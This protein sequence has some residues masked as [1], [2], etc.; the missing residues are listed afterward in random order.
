MKKPKNLASHIPMV[1]PDIED[2]RHEFFNNIPHDMTN[3]GPGKCAEEK[4]VP[5]KVAP[6]EELVPIDSAILD[7]LIQKNYNEQVQRK[8]YEWEQEGVAEQCNPSCNITM[9]QEIM[10]CAPDVVQFTRMDVYPLVP[11]SLNWMLEA[12]K[13]IGKNK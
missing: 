12:Q 11:W 9:T 6:V 1:G 2:T 13:N 8:I 7:E 4:K 5:T 3:K 10:A